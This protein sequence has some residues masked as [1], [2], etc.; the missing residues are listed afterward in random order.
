MAKKP[1]TNEIARQLF[2]GDQYLIF[3]KIIQTFQDEENLTREE[4][5]SYY[6]QL[7]KILLSGIE[8]SKTRIVSIQIDSLYKKG[9]F[10]N[11]IRTLVKFYVLFNNNPSCVS[12]FPQT[13]TSLQTIIP[14]FKHILDQKESMG[15]ISTVVRHLIKYN[16]LFPDCNLEYIDS[17][18]DD[19]ATKKH[20]TANK[21]D[22]N[23]INY[24]KSR[25][26]IK[27]EEML[28]KN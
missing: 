15:K 19:I 1:T 26:K 21:E 24:L 12:G 11:S 16:H 22:K 10:L 8:D 25:V 18:L 2:I 27:K 5:Q 20:L 14:T 23:E 6:H 3:T 13:S 4:R 7:D 17:Y 28:K 9:E